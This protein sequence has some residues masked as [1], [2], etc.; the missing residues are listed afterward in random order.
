MGNIFSTQ[1]I[2]DLIKRVENQKVVFTNGCFDLLHPGHI[3]YLTKAKALGDVLIVGLN[4]D[5]S[6][7]QIKGDIRPINNQ[8]FRSQMLLGLKPVDYVVIFEDDTPINTINKIK[9]HVHVKGGDYIASNLP[10]Y[11]VVKS[12]GGQIEILP[13]LDGFSSTNIINKIKSTLI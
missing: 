1:T 3:D 8:S 9:P 7:K 11:K 4:S 5:A 12:Y 2:Q 10:E 13:F 6:V